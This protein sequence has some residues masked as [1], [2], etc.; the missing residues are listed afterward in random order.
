M[1]FINEVKYSCSQK[2]GVIFRE[3][4]N[5]VIDYDG[6]NVPDLVIQDLNISFRKSFGSFGSLLSEYSFKID[7]TRWP[8][9][10]DKPNIVI[11]TNLISLNVDSPDFNV[12]IEKIAEENFSFD[13]NNDNDEDNNNGNGDGDGNGDNGKGTQPPKNKKIWGLLQGLLLQLL[14]LSL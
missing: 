10:V 9:D 3:V 2:F 4:I 7:A 8:E 11:T 5:L 12:K 1:K 14:L 13:D 6:K